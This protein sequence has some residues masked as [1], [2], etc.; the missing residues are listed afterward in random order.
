MEDIDLNKLLEYYNG[1]SFDNGEPLIWNN[2][3]MEQSKTLAYIEITNRSKK[4]QTINEV[5]HKVQELTQLFNDLKLILRMPSDIFIVDTRYSS[6]TYDFCKAV[7]KQSTMLYNKKL[8]MINSQIIKKLEEIELIWKYDPDNLRYQS[9]FGGRELPNQYINGNI[10]THNWIC[11]EK[12]DF[13]INISSYYINRDFT[14]V[15]VQNASRYEVIIYPIYSDEDNGL[16]YLND[17]ILNLVATNQKN[18]KLIICWIYNKS[19]DLE[20]NELNELVRKDKI[21]EISNKLLWNKICHINIEEKESEYS[22]KELIDK[23]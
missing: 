14:K 20:L 18:L 19:D 3:T 21:E 23:I 15:I 2:C 9:K 7:S 17:F 10:E 8:P 16:F 4:H 6:E 12:Q 11:T 5:E 1:F 22:Y 13:R